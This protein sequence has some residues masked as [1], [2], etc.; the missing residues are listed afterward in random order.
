MKLHNVIVIKAERASQKR[1]LIY[2][3]MYPNNRDAEKYH[4]VMTFP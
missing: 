4:K 3:C 1:N 2:L